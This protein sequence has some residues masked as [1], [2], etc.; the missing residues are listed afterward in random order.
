MTEE[1]RKQGDSIGQ[2]EVKQAIVEYPAQPEV[3]KIEDKPAF[4]FPAIAA[5]QN[6]L[7]QLDQ[8]TKEIDIRMRK[9]DQMIAE[10][11]V[12]GRAFAG[13]P[14]E[15]TKEELEIEAAKKLLEGTGLNPFK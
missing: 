12:S 2:P 6:I 3:V 9:L 10:Q 13:Q 8:K 7:A 1:I 4:Q 14:R 11:M 5:A 15:P